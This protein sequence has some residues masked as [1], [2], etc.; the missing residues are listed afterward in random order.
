YFMGETTSNEFEIN[1][2]GIGSLSAEQMNDFEKLHDKNLIS[3]EQYVDIINRTLP[4]ELVYEKQESD[5]PDNEDDQDSDQ[6]D[7]DND[8][9]NQDDA[10]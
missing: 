1:S 4:F 9:E 7:Q 2:V 6:N 5:T 8:T 3:D 10:D